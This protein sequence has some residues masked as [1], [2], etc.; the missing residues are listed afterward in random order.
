MR[1]GLPDRA[2]RYA[3]AYAA[4]EPP[5]AH[6]PSLRLAAL[7]FDSGG[8]GAPAVDRALRSATANTLVRVGHD[9]L[10][11]WTDSAETAVLVLRELVRGGHDVAGA[12]P[13]VADPRMWGKVLASALALRGRLREAAEAYGGL[14]TDSDPP[15][16]WALDDPFRDF[17]LLEVVADSII[18]RAFAQ[19][20]R[21]DADWD[22]VELPRHLRGLPWWLARGDTLALAR[23]GRRAAEVARTFDRPRPALRARYLG[24]AATAYLALVRGD[25]AGAVRVFDAIP[26]SLCYVGN[27]FFE[28]LTLARLLAAR[29]DE[30]R[31]AELLDRWMWAEGSTPAF[32][33]ASLERARLA[34]RLGERD[35][36]STF[37]RFVAEIWRRAEPSL[38]PY[39][40]EA[41]AGLLRLETAAAR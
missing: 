2:R 26:D 38:W 15:P 37:Y 23:F 6:A 31:A 14:L 27:C 35:K 8:A 22:G 11:W 1:L 5:E 12:P 16:F 19:S 10:R 39:V 17:G 20:W 30:G 13:F 28:K 40:E 29:G 7:V 25:S 21:P 32:V 18:G 9:H 3:R 24:E 4:L 33:L 34:E 41:H 36:A